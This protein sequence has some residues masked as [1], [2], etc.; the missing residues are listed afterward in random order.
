[1]YIMTEALPIKLIPCVD[2]SCLLCDQTDDATRKID[3]IFLIQISFETNR[4]ELC[5][6]FFID[7]HKKIIRK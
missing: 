3:P 5:I 7:F 1:M 2:I 6:T 4:N